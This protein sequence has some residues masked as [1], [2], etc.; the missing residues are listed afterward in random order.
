L[1]NKQIE[2]GCKKK[3]IR[4]EKR[5]KENGKAVMHALK[6]CIGTD[7]KVKTPEEIII[8]LTF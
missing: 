4:E 6:I 1:E 8:K 2:V 7:I 3:V 5:N